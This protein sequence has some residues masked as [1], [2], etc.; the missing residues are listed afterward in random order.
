MV[1]DFMVGLGFA[2]I[3][4]SLAHGLLLSLIVFF[5]A[6]IRGYAGFGF[7]VVAGASL[8]MPTKEVVPLVLVMEILASLQR[9]QNIWSGINW[10]L[11]LWIMVGSLIFVPLGRGRESS[12]PMMGRSIKKSL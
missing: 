10:R 4:L 1:Y 12:T 9:A 7:S 8:F 2:S 11:L 5:A 6:I 3:E